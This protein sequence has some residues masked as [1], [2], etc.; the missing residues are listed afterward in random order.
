MQLVQDTGPDPGPSPHC[1]CYIPPP[2]ASNLPPASPA[3]T[4]PHYT[5]IP[6]AHLYDP[7]GMVPQDL[8]ERTVER[9]LPF[10]RLL[11]APCRLL[12]IILRLALIQVLQPVP[13]SAVAPLPSSSSGD[14]R[15][16]R[17]RSRP[18]RLTSCKRG[19][20]QAGS[21]PAGQG[22]SLGPRPSPHVPVPATGQG[23]CLLGIMGPYL[24]SH[25]L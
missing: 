16:R 6:H 24:L 21:G 12:G 14:G 11:G 7:G 1:T 8:E 20:R 23:Y 5:P 10:G 15:R 9:L 3:H 2:P 13:G 25:C 22:Q 17:R 18:R 19:G 4:T